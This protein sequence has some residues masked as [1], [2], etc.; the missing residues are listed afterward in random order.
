[1]VRILHVCLM[2]KEQRLGSV[3]T[4]VNN[5]EQQKA[6]LIVPVF[7]LKAAA[8]VV[9]AAAHSGSHQRSCKAM[10]HQTRS[11]GWLSQ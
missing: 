9:T 7:I 11:D 2:H 5:A 10:Q 3:Q 8:A 1:M 6:S 4:S